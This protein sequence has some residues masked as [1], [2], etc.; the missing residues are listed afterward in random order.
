MKNKINEQWYSLKRRISVYWIIVIVLAAALPY[1]LYINHFNIPVAHSEEAIDNCAL[2]YKLT[3]EN[4]NKLVQPLLYASLATEDENLMPLKER[5]TN[6]IN[7]KKDGVLKNASV[8]FNVLDSANGWFVINPDEK[9]NPASIMKVAFVMTM[10]KEAEN[11]PSILDKKVYFSEHSTT[12]HDQNII[13]HPLSAGKSYT[14]KELML[15]AL[16]YSDN[17]A[18]FKVVDNFKEGSLQNLMKA[19]NLPLVDFHTEYYTTVEELSRLFRVLYNS[20][21]LSNEMSEYAL[22]L[23]SQSD[24]NDGI[25]KKLDKN[26][27]VAR[28]FGERG[29]DAS[30]ELHEYGIVYLHDRPY[31][32]GI[33]TRGRD[34]NELEEVISDISLM[35]YEEMTKP[36]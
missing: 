17:D 29:I 31:L 11:N 35:A 7:G 8:Y 34:Y 23:L 2:P 30:R 27:I 22:E 16:A 33:M 21:Y 32:L 3:R 26:I 13:H 9:Y 1:N 19:L 12:F 28:K 14:I 24:F 6:Y 18:A 4:N 36:L 20:S 25:V 5:I 15:Y 10:L